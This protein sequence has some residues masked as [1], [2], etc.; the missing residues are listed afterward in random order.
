VAYA[1][2]K[3]LPVPEPYTRTKMLRIFEQWR[4]TKWDTYR[5]LLI[6]VRYTHM[7]HM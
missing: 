3:K 2:I 1:I 7:T 6:V 5:I 4:T